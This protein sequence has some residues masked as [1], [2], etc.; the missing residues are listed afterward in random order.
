LYTGLT[1]YVKQ[2]IILSDKLEEANT[3]SSAV[4]QEGKPRFVVASGS[5]VSTYGNGFAGSTVR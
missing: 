3:Q 1:T 2:I 4:K 5:L